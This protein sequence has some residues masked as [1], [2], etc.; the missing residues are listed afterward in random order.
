MHIA[1]VNFHLKDMTHDQFAAVCDQI[2][3]T[4]AAIPGL[5][6][7]VWLSDPASNTYGGVYLWE[8]RPAFEAFAAGELAAGMA[9]NPNFTDLSIRDF[10]VLDAPTRVTRGMPTAGARA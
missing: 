4:W 6:S 9:K 7:K 5:I 1:V 3:P 10:D 8:D 2:A